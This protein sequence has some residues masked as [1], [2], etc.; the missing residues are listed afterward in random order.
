M[1]PRT[2]CPACGSDM[3]S[4]NLFSTDSLKSVRTCPDCSARYTAD[5]P[6]RR[7]QWLILLLF[8]V[9]MALTALAY[10]WGFAWLWPALLSCV[11]LMAYVAYAVSKLVYVNAPENG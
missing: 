4:R 2:N 3:R 7:R 9:C 8:L 6:S 11:A 10:V 5:K 1:P